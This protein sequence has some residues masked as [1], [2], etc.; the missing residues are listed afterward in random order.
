[1]HCHRNSH[2]LRQIRCA[3]AISH[4]RRINGMI[5]RL[6]LVATVAVSFAEIGAPAFT[7]A[8]EKN[9]RMS[10]EETHMSIIDKIKDI[11]QVTK[12]RVVIVPSS[13]AFHITLSEAGLWSLGCPFVTKD[14]S[15]VR[16]LVD[17][18]KG[19]DISVVEPTEPGW[20][21][22][23]REGVSLLL[24]SGSE[25]RLMFTVNFT[26]TGVR[27]YLDD[28]GSS[29]SSFVVQPELRSAYTPGGRTYLTAKSTLPDQLLTWAASIGASIPDGLPPDR[30]R[31]VQRACDSLANSK[32]N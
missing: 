31:L 12:A 5:S 24:P 11:D 28:F 3:A 23:Y 30:H 17:I 26:N 8:A 18:L 1:M 14:P 27:G 2:R 6:F 7:I 29:R 16:N 20:F 32:V 19:A 22:E 21:G 9:D 4:Q 15:R 25:V 10:T 13:F